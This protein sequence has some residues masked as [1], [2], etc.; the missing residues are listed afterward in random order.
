MINSPTAILIDSDCGWQNTGVQT[1]KIFGKPS[2]T[3]SSKNGVINCCSKDSEKEYIADPLKDIENYLARGLTCV[4]YISY[5]FSGFT[6]PKF[7]VR[8]DKEGFTAFDTCFHCYEE[9]QVEQC[10]F[11]E[12]LTRIDETNNEPVRTKSS[13]LSNFEKSDYLKIVEIARDYISSGDIYQVNLS[14]KFS[15]SGLEN[16]YSSL[17]KFYEAQPVPFSA[18]IEFDDHTVVSGSMELFLRRDGSIISTKPIK[19]TA[20]RSRDIKN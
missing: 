15:T 13:H 16:S 20:K 17:I 4:G 14:Q 2:F 11:D 10:S 19:G 7:T 18:I 3:V 5:E 8:T 9:N 6:T 12:L 1:V